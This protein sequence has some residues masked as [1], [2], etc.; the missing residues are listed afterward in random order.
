MK[1]LIDK[2]LYNWIGYGNY[3]GDV[4]FIGMEEGG[5]EIWREGIATLTLEELEPLRKVKNDEVI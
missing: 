3:N 1:D 2:C 5:A 4:W